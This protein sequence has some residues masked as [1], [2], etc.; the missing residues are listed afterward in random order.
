MR[1]TNE[2]RSPKPN[3]HRGPDFEARTQQAR[4]QDARGNNSKS[5]RVRNTKEK[6]TINIEET[7]AIFGSNKADKW[8]EAKKRS[9]STDLQK[10][11]A[12][13]IDMQKIKREKIKQARAIRIGNQQT[14]VSVD[15]V[16]VVNVYFPLK[17]DGK[18]KLT[19][20]RFSDLKGFV[21]IQL[22]K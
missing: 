17:Y 6:A 12:L 22:K 20:L 15:R 13:R 18:V 16:T 5:F 21:C 11:A 10:A 14:V 19:N 2:N 7:L 9:R 8:A 1:M 4:K 3:A